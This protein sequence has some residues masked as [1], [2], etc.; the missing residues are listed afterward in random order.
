MDESTIKMTAPPP[1]LPTPRP[2]GANAPLPLWRRLAGR[3]LALVSF[4][5]RRPGRT[6]LLIAV[7]LTAGFAAVAGGVLVRFQTHLRA[8]RVEVGRGHN[9][10]ATRHLNTCR[11]LR[12]DHPEVLILAARVARRSGSWTEAETLLDRYWAKYGDEDRLVFE[13]LLLRTT[14]GESGAMSPS[15]LA[16]IEAGGPDAPLAREALV[17]GLLYQFRWRQAERAIADWLE[18]APDETTAI[19]LRG[20]LQEQRAQTSESLLSFRRVVELDPDHDEARLRLTTLLLQLRQGEEAVAH[21]DYLRHRL[22]DNP[23]VKVQWS[24]ALALQGRAAEARAAL[25]DCLR[26]HPD[27]PAALVDQGKCETADGDDKAAEEYLDRAARLDPGNLTTRHLHAL[28]LARTGKAAAADE[29]ET[30]RRLEADFE[31]INQLI[32]GPLQMTPDDPAV[33]HEIATI[34]LRAGQSAEALRWLQSA[35]QVR[36]DHQPTHQLLA[37]YYHETGAPALAAKHRALARR[38]GGKQDP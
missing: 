37:A 20:K 33:H 3:P 29:L 23:E 32:Q 22:P 14:R 19:L 18:A 35:L 2:G 25:T 10:A 17:T 11:D 5:R 38:P 36:P 24:R 12:P 21:L 27:C 34:A 28:A 31:R 13:R 15:L 8:A 7:L 16:R 4:A 1:G 6:I 26:A 30:I 9:A